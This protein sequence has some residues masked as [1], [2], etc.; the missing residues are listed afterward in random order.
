MTAQ[1]IRPMTGRIEVRGLRAPRGDEPSNRD[2]FRTA[3]GLVIRPTWLDAD[4]GKPGWQGYWTISRVH[5]T[6]VAEV[7][8]IRDGEVQIEMH[9]SQTEQCDL[10]CQTAVGDDCTCSCEGEHH[11]EGQHASWKEVGN[12][13]LVRGSGTKAVTRVLTRKQALDDQRSNE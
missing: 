2:M 8:A 10:R 1:I 4:E 13:T 6:A 5:L 12:T 3:T 11:G 7:I 9:Y